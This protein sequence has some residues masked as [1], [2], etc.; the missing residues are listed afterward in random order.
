MKSRAVCWTQFIKFNAPDGYKMSRCMKCG[1]EYEAD[2]FL[3]GTNAMNV[4]MRKGCGDKQGTT[5]QLL[6][7]G[8]TGVEGEGTLTN[9]KF[10][11]EA[12]RKGLAY[13]L[14]VDEK[15]FKFVDGMGFKYFM[16]L[17]CPMFNIP[18]RRTITRDCFAFYSEMKE[19]EKIF[20]KL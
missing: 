17:C 8:K 3:N 4:H 7:L 11:Q 10:D 9:W 13:M 12:T 19:I 1:K 16:P 2:P 15:P 6:N 20:S 5:Q 18:S 14:I